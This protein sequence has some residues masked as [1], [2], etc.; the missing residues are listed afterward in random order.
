VRRHGSSFAS[1]ATPSPISEAVSGNSMGSQHNVPLGMRQQS[2]WISGRIISISLCIL[3]CGVPLIVNPFA[4]DFYYQP[5]IS[6]VY[7]LIGI[8]AAA[9]VAL[10]MLS[11][12]RFAF[13]WTPLTVPLCAY[14][15]SAVLS[16]LF[17]IAP[18]LSLLGDAWRL[19]SVITL[20]A[21]VG[22]V[23]IFSGLVSSARQAEQL[24]SGL[25]A[26]AGLVA[27]YGLAQY[28]GYNLTEHFD[29]LLRHNRIN[30][31]IGNTNF[32]GKFL[33]LVCPL[34]LA[35]CLAAAGA[36]RQVLLGCGLVACLC[37]IF[38]T[39]TRASWL[40]LLCAGIIFLSTAGGLQLRA[41]RKA[42]G[43]L[44][45]IA[46]LFCL[47]LVLYGAA[48]KG[49]LPG[50]RIF[51]VKERLLAT[52][53]LRHGP[54]SATRLFVWQKVVKLILQRPVVGYGPDTHVIPMSSFNQEYIRRFHDRVIID[55][56]HNNYLDIAVAQGLIGLGAY[57][58]IIVT[59]LIWLR[60][61]IAAELPGGRRLLLCGIFAG[62][63]GYLIN[64]FFIFSVVSVSPTFWSLM[65]LTFALP[66]RHDG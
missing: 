43:A 39:F 66:E 5:K 57:L 14:A 8:I 35:G 30:S 38:L 10:R 60:K 15:G 17:S 21:Y 59:F 45:I 63:C 1:S 23:F 20:L 27:L 13:R 4:Y 53:D 6:S 52:W 46:L 37:T 24:L 49:N 33:V 65:G 56:A 61:R 47:G 32:L 50:Q 58:A 11:G 48:R 64:D 31:T 41:K 3:L 29:P 51:T 26:C 36:A 40:G 62:F 34:F 9:A 16:T 44:I 28:A 54:G 7:A 12:Q 2:I 42:I 22:L 18:R 55:R 25:L 19:E